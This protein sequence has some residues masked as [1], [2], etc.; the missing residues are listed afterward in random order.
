MATVEQFE[1]FCATEAQVTQ[2]LS[3]VAQKKGYINS[4]APSGVTRSSAR[5]ETNIAH[6]VLAQF[7]VVDVL[8]RYYTGQVEMYDQVRTDEFK[9]HDPWDLRVDVNDQWYHVEVRSSYIQQKCEDVADVLRCIQDEYNLI[10]N[11]ETSYKAKEAQKHIFFQVYWTHVQQVAEEL[12]ASEALVGL[13]CYVVGWATA[14]QVKEEGSTT[15]L[16]QRNAKYCVLPI[17]KI[18]ACSALKKS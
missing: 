2:A 16:G 10:A 18:K 12:Y 3:I 6:G 5:I 7:A 17:R 11:Y 8:T 15:N 9:D 1:K 4:K 14:K 13:C